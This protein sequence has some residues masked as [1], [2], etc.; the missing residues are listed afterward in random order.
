MTTI[1]KE[2]SLSP[3]IM[4]EG[5]NHKARFVSKLPNGDTL[6]FVVWQI[7]RDPLAEI[8]TIEIGHEGSSGWETIHRIN[9]YRSSD[10]RSVLLPGKTNNCCPFGS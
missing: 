5:R 4:A 10:G 2:D 8:V 9:I 7:D 1:I 3:V 6:N